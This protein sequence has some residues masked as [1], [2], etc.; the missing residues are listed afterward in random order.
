LKTR[1]RRCTS[2]HSESSNRSI[3]R[4]K[5]RERSTGNGHKPESAPKTKKAVCW[6]VPESCRSHD[7]SRSCSFVTPIFA[8]F[9][10]FAL[11]CRI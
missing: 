4:S 10:R 7:T 5:F 6:C 2:P 3:S 1:P 11:V 8:L 9:Q